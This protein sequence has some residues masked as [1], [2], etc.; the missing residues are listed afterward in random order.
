MLFVNNL[1]MK[2]QLDAEKEIEKSS[3]MFPKF[4]RTAFPDT[5]LL[6]HR[7]AHTTGL[8][9]GEVTFSVF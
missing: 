4:L 8:G 3:A 1:T 5:R 6:I 7:K 2:R 9:L